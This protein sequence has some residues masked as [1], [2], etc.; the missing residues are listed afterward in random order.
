MAVAMIVASTV[1]EEP[2]RACRTCYRWDE[3]DPVR[4]GW[5][6]CHAGCSYWGQPRDEEDTQM[7]ATAQSQD[8]GEGQFA[9]LHAHIRTAGDFHCAMWDPNKPWEEQPAPAAD[10]GGGEEG[11]D[12]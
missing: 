7:F 9:L 12:G 10:G 11:G 2:E 3:S 6:L 1:F 4:P 5:G 8:E